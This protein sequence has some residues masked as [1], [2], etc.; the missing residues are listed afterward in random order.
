MGSF[1]GWEWILLLLL[2]AI[3]AVVI[4]VIVAIVKAAS[5]KSKPPLSANPPGWLPDPTDP[6]LLRY[7]DGTQWTGTA[8]K[9]GAPT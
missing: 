9:G 2:I 6:D 7:W 4:F 5:V 3:V 1:R 8:R